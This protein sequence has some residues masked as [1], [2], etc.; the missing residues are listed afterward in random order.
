MSFGKIL[1]DIEGQLQL[2][3]QELDEL[4]AKVAEAR[5]RVSRLRKAHRDLTGEPAQGKTRQRKRK[6][7]NDWKPGP[8]SI[9]AVLTVLSEAGES[10]P[11]KEIEERSGRSH[12]HIDS[13]VRYLRDH[14]LIRLDGKRGTA[15]VY[16][17]MPNTGLKETENAANAA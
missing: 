2:E 17:L 5:E 13:V 6:S 4:E 12:S 10:L 11:I 16:A 8:E 15:Y 14:D 9:Q 1:S 7:N 3:Q